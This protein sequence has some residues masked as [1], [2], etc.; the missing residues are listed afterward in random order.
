MDSDPVL[1]S[2]MWQWVG[3]VLAHRLVSAH[4]RLLDLYAPHGSGSHI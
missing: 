1:A 2:A 4:I 3:Q